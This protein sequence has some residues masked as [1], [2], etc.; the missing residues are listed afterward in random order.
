MDDVTATDE[1]RVAQVLFLGEQDYVYA[2]YAEELPAGW[3]LQPLKSWDEADRLDLSRYDFA[4]HRTVDVTPEVLER[5]T[6]L[7]LVQRHGVGLDSLNVSALE[8]RG[9]PV[10][11]AAAGTNDVAELALALL[12]ACSRRVVELDRETRRGRWPKWEHTEETVALCDRTVAVV[13]LGRIGLRVAASLCHLGSS[14]IG[15]GRGDAR[16]AELG[17]GARWTDDLDAALEQ[18][19]TLTVHVPLNRSTTGLITGSRLDLLGRDGIVVNTSRGAVLDEAALADSLRAGRLLAAGLDVFRREPPARDNPL[20]QLPNV[21]L[22]P[23]VGGSTR[24]G[25]RRKAR[26]AYGNMHTALREHGGS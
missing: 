5:M 15:V 24:L 9:I 20:L 7:K 17:A 8:E 4:L 19:D 11:G 12:L 16:P 2:I 18:A 26:E 10:A 1:P 14:V 25:M 13:G 22:T 21:I 6:S 3:T 23:H